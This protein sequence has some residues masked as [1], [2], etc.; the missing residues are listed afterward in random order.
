MTHHPSLTAMAD[1]TFTK[2]PSASLS[3]PTYARVCE[4]LRQDILSGRFPHGSRLKIAE[5][6]AIY[7]VSQMPVREALQQLQ[8]EGLVVISPNRGA[9]VRA[10]DERLVRNLYD[11][12]GA[13]EMMLVERCAQAIDEMQMF[14]LYGLASRHEEAM[15]CADV[16]A[17]IEFNR[18]FHRLIYSAA[19]NPEAI[20]I[21]ERQWDLV[22]A[23][24]RRHGFGHERIEQV[25]SE[26]RRLLRAL[27][28]RDAPLA[29]SV[30]WEHCQ[31]AKEDLI[32][33]IRLART[34]P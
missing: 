16:A 25:I 14:D 33:Q 3:L 24:R 29:K 7:G 23:L 9:T 13:I 8:G 30:M 21:I 34:A 11:I 10:V 19:D 5:L 22:S 1:S 12:R 6:S 2:S 32:Q 31:H 28:A 18:R 26:H 27:D 20:E 17:A 15:R 4:Q